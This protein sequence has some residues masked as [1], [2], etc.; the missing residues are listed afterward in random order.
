M[1]LSFLDLTNELLVTFNESQLAFTDFDNQRGIQQRA[2]NA[3]QYAVNEIVQEPVEW[4]FLSVE[5]SVNLSIGQTDYDWP[6]NLSRADWDSFYI[7]KD[8]V[9]NTQKTYNLKYIDRD[10]W[11]ND[12]R[13]DDI[14]FSVEGIE[15][16]RFVFP[17]MNG[18]GVS[19]APDKTYSLKYRYFKKPTTLVNYNDTTEI[20]EEWRHVINVGASWYI[21]IFRN[22]PEDANAINQKF[23][24]LKNHMRRVLIP[25][26]ER[27]RDTRSRR[28]VN[29]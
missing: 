27:I 18:F 3:V 10:Q 16:P 4:P 22:N 29:G 9:Y 13:P 20:P 6:T 19:P 5:T 14:D 21:H 12:Y 2:K 7:V 8:G 23:Q 24:M 1:A 15:L 17:S 26:A 28:H 11:Y 25:N